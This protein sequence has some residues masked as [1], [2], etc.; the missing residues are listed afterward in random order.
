MVLKEEHLWKI[1][2]ATGLF[3]TL[4]VI[5]A[6][7]VIQSSPDFAHEVDVT[8]TITLISNSLTAIVFLYLVIFPPRLF[9]YAGLCFFNGLLNIVMG[10]DIIGFLLYVLGT[11][12][13]FRGEFFREKARTKLFALVLILLGALLFQILTST[14]QF[15][16]SL[17][18]IGVLAIIF[19]LLLF[20]FYPFL[21]SLMP[22]PAEKPVIDLGTFDMKNR[23][24]D[25]LKRVLA[26]EK[27][28][29]IANSYHIS[30]STIKQRMLVLYKKLGVENRNEFLLLA[31][32]S[33]LVFPGASEDESEN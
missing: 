27:Y 20:L 21:T 29:S 11:A 15:L 24:L 10:G 9:V 28:D 7:I 5:I 30:E 1:I 18:Y 26:N 13:L 6:N 32:K 33:E 14:A 25:F 3:F 12:F 8:S 31:S 2:P 22:E 16:H 19:A 4:L 23:D 17:L